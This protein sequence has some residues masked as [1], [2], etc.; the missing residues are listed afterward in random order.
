MRFIA[1]FAAAFLA[2]SIPSLAMPP[3]PRKAPELTIVDLAGNQ[4]LLSSYKGKVVII[5]FLA[6]TCIHCQH[7]TEMFIKLHKELGP[8]GFQPLG[9]AAYDNS[10]QQVNA[11]IRQFGPDYP[12]GIAN[13]DTVV[14]YLGFSLMDRVMVPQIVVIDRKGMIR[15]QTPPQGDASLQDETYLRNLITALLNEGG[16]VKTT[17]R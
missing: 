8:R 10:P 11:F 15:A 12:I 5:E 1:V 6:T 4:T 13:N 7:A 17:K 14:N 9:I 16:P 2:L 3:L